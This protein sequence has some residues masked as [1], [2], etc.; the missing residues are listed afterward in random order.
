MWPVVEVVALGM[1]CS[2]Y[3]CSRPWEVRA[4]KGRGL[5]TLGEVGSC[6]RK[7][8]VRNGSVGSGEVTCT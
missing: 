5:G 1:L 7:L 6:G 8:L 4:A 3:T 2:S